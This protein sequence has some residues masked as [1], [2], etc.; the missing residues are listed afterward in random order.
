[1]IPV[2]GVQ[3]TYKHSAKFDDL[4]EI[5]VTIR[6]YTGVKLV[7]GYEIINKTNNDL[8]V[9]TGETKHCFTNKEMKPI[10]LKRINPKI[11]EIFLNSFN[12]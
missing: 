5:K 8:L 10:S 11:H 4:I 6:E 1:M 9:L 7:V 2:I 12:E 3:C